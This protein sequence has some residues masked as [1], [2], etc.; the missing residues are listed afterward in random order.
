MKKWWGLC[1]AICLS[2]AVVQAQT[3]SYEE[4]DCPFIENDPEISCGTLVTLQD[5]A[6]PA[7]GEI[8]LQVVVIASTSDSPASAPIIYFEGGPGGSAIAAYSAWL[9]SGLREYSD[10][11]LLDQRGTGF[12][13]PLLNCIENDDPELEDPV[14]ACASRLRDEEGIDLSDYNSANNARDVA[15][16]V[17]A[18]GYDE[19]NLFGVSYGTRLALTVMRDYPELVRS[20]IIDAVYPPHVQAYEEQAPNAQDAFDALFE[21]CA[22]DSACNAAYP[23]LRQTL[24]DAVDALNAE[25]MLISDETGEVGEMTGDNF[26]DE[27]FQAL[28]DPQQIPYLPARIYAV[29]QG[30]SDYANIGL[31]EDDLGAS[32]E[33]LENPL[34]ALSEEEYFAAA[35]SALGFESVEAL[36]EYLASLSEEAY[37]DTLAQADALLLG[38]IDDDSE[39]MFHSVECV[40]EV[41]FNRYEVAEQMAEGVAP[42]IASAMLIGVDKQIADCQVWDV[43][44]ADALENAPVVSDIPTLV[45]SGSFDPVTP[46]A[47]GESTASYLSNSSFWVFP[48]GHGSVDVDD[49]PTGMAL[50]FLNNLTPPDGS[51]IAGMAMEFY[52]D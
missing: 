33:L 23:E 13:L 1:C 21:A 7:D 47:W 10:L 35:A 14:S 46:P 16:L 9:E 20:V 17:R 8:V 28:Y 43:S 29:Y 4:G 36:D 50:S 30:D 45:M 3:A 25:P 24:Y 12:S 2:V 49:C 37:E 38:E 39:G 34:D 41:P 5:Y 42:Q 44:P 51:C 15:E 32:D 26:V 27:L 31:A 48:L 40:E 18:M 11:I 6:N 22:A 19:V 52:V